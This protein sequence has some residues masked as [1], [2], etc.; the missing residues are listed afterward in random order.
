MWGV[1]P[2]TRTKLVAQGILTIG[3]LAHAPGH[4]LEKRLGHAAGEQ[5]RAL[6]WNRNPREI[7]TRHRASSAGAPS[8]LGR[9]PAE[10]RVFRPALLHLADRVGSRL[11]AKSLA[12]R[13]V[14]VRVRFAD[15]RSVTRSITLDTP[16]S[17]SHLQSPA[18][19]QL[20]LPLGLADE[21]RRPGTRMGIARSD[22]DRAIDAMDGRP[23][24]TDR[25]SLKPRNPSQT[26]SVNSPKRICSRRYWPSRHHPRPPRDTCIAL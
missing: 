24:D 12:G 16:I 7:R 22:A 3:Q 19:M 18:V 8:A 9:R 2:V 14:T 17:L 6:A 4:S 15:L 11:R 23:S 25:P 13:T 26:N 20:D 10:E 5:L 1:G 21:K